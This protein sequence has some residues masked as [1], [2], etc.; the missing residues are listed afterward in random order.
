MMEKYHAAEKI[1][2]DTDV[3]DDRKNIK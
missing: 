3:S 1:D 2:P